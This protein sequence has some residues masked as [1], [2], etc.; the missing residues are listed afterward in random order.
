LGVRPDYLIV[1]HPHSDHI[2][3]LDALRKVFPG[4]VVVAG[5]GAAAFLD[6]PKAIESLL[7]ED[8]HMASFIS[9]Q[10]LVSDR[11]AIECFSSLSGCK[12]VTGG[13]VLD[14]GETKVR[15]L[16]ARGHAPGSILVYVEEL[17]AILV[18]DSLGYRV[19]GVGFFPIFFTGYAEYMATIDVIEALKPEILGLAHHCLMQGAD[20]QKA[21]QEAR[22]AA[23]SAI[24]RIVN[25]KRED[26]IV[27]RD[28]FRDCYHD[29]LTLYT[30][31][32]ILACCRLLVRRA[33]EY[34]KSRRRN[35]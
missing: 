15:F 31:E 2:C 11:P 12:T 24:G 13:E 4:A 25:D 19:S 28:L 34:Q 3:G 21:I 30:K 32:N 29:E 27:V 18:S 33:R 23:R 7:R 20:V 35:G 1:T 9:N 17:N 16:E 5:D 22:D 26:E 8:R 10:G 6:H 14:L